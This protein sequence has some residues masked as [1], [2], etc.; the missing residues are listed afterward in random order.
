[1]HVGATAL[2]P[3]YVPSDIGVSSRQVNPADVPMTPLDEATLRRAGLPQEG[4][5][6]DDVTSAALAGIEADRAH[7]I[8]YRGGT[9]E[10]DIRTRVQGVLDDLRP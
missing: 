6:M 2:C 10:A 1:P 3:G 7:V 5:T 8:V 9:Y 4:L